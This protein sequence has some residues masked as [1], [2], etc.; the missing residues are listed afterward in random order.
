MNNDTTT[1]N[2]TYTQ[3]NA[4]RTSSHGDK[5]FYELITSRKNAQLNIQS[6]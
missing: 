3:P 4:E 1:N 6:K 2:T 5:C